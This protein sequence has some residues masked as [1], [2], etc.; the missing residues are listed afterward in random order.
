MTIFI[1]SH[2][3]LEWFVIQQEIT[4]ID[5]DFKELKNELESQEVSEPSQ[6]Y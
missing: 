1:L 3:I 4:R 5:S 6:V 2:W